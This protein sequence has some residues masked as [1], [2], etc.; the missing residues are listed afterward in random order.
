MFSTINDEKIKNGRVMKV[1]QNTDNEY[2]TEQL[3][4]TLENNKKIKKNID[5][6]GTLLYNIVVL[7]VAM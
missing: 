6:D 3:L 2:L 1:L 5:K 4:K 7:C